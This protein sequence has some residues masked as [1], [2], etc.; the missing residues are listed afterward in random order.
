MNLNHFLIFVLCSE[1]AG[2]QL[3]YLNSLQNICYVNAKMH[4]K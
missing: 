4:N 3:H 1:N 2:K